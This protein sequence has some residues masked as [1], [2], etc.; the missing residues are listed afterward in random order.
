MT[1][2]FLQNYHVF[3]YFFCTSTLSHRFD[4]SLSLCLYDW[5]IFAKL[6]CN[7]F[8]SCMYF[9]LFH[10]SDISLDVCMT[11]VFQQNDPVMF[12]FLVC[13]STLTQI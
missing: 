11:G 1:G 6:S 12:S 7:V 8:F 5:D 3:F 4:I 2:I 10:R 9:P 13:T